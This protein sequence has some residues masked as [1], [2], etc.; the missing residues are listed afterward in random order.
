MKS[1]TSQILYRYWNEVRGGRLAPTRLEI[2]PSRITE[3]LSET[4]ILEAADGGA[5]P[6]RL[7]GTRICE[8]LGTE[9]R[10]RD[11]VDLVGSEHAATVDEV[12]AAV[13]AQGA[14]ARLELEATADDGRIVVFETILLPLLHARQTVSRYLGAMAALEPPPWLGNTALSVRGLVGH[15][16]VW[17]DG[18]PHAVVERGGNQSPFLP[19]M[20]GARV[21][22]QDRRQFRVLDGGRTRDK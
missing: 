11:F 16:L 8:H 2:E 6:F 17:P 13:T 21:V 4:F 22:R 5:F 20:L 9:L 19:G 10:G 7:A 15:E 3:I 14:V 1:R 12:L 18:R